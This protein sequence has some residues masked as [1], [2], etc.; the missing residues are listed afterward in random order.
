MDNMSLGYNFPA[1]WNNKLKLRISAGVTNVF[2]ITPYK[3]LDPEVAGGLDD[4]FFPRARIY[5]LGLNA[6]L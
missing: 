1:Y 4:N 5:Q 3:G 6:T 2:T